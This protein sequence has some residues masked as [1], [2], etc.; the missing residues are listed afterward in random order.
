MNHLH[1]QQNETIMEIH[2]IIYAFGG[3]RAM[4]YELLKLT[5]IVT[6]EQRLINLNHPLIDKAPISANTL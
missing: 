2:N 6:A 1:Q 5:G 4:S 3:I